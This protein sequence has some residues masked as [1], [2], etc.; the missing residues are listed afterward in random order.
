[1]TPKT[2]ED[3][4][5]GVMKGIPA[6]EVTIDIGGD[7]DIVDIREELEGRISDLITTLR[8]ESEEAITT[9]KREVLR[10]VE[11][12]KRTDGVIFILPS[13]WEAITHLE[14]ELTPLSN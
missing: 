5:E 8:K 11:R 12:Y 4:I 6:I 7:T 2:T 9:A 14:S 1:M 13:Q 10:E 3:Y